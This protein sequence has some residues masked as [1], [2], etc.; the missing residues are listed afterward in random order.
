MVDNGKPY[1]DVHTRHTLTIDDVGN[2]IEQVEVTFTYGKNNVGKI[3]VPTSGLS[4]QD[5][6]QRIMDYLNVFGD[7]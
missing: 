1:R 4:K 5:I 6:H 2:T 3:Y 7:L